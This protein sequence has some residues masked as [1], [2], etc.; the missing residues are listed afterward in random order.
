M[1]KL[2]EI[3]K[4]NEV[5][6]GVIAVPSDY[7][8]KITDLLVNNN[9]TTILNFAPVAINVPKN[10]QLRNVDLSVNLEILTFNMVNNLTN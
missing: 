6:I 3:I 9:I 4:K 2:G 7:A 5:K 8:Q 10:V 1:G